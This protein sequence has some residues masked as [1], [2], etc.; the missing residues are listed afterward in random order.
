M[1]VVAVRILAYCDPNVDTS[2]IYGR[3]S[4]TTM[5]NKRGILKGIGKIPYLYRSFRAKQILTSGAE[6]KT[7][8][9][10]VKPG[11]SKQAVNDIKLINPD[12]LKKV[13]TGGYG[14]PASNTMFEGRIGGDVVT[15][16][17]RDDGKA[18][19]LFGR[20][21]SLARVITVRYE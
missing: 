9:D 11:G 5:R 14:D 8:S 4:D 18:M 6:K 12:G 15:M 20:D 10:Y 17:I 16:I 2:G 1:L 13:V 19:I 21:N 7:G 3:K